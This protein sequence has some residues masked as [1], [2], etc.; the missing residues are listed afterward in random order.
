MAD[1]IE[2]LMIEVRAVDQRLCRRRGDDAGELRFGPGRRVRAGRRGARARAASGDPPRQPGVRGP[3]ADRPVGDR[4]HRRRAR[5]SPGSGRL[6]GGGG[7]SGGGGLFNLG[8][9][10]TTVLGGAS[11]QPGRATGGL[12]SAGRGYLVGERGPELFVPTAAG[13]VEPKRQARRPRGQGRDPD[14]QPARIERARKPPALQPPGRPRGPQRAHA[15]LRNRHALLACRQA[16]RAG[17]RLDP[18]VRPAVLDG[19]FPPPDA[20]RRDRA[21]AGR[22]ADRRGVPQGERSRRDHLGERRTAGTTRCSRSRPTATIRTRSCRSAGARRGC[23]RST[24][25]MVRP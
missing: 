2:Q 21:C 9:L 1:E 15:I 23:C 11:G 17:G 7:G 19:R 13:R 14:R 5:S 25:S 3:A 22:A 16:H 18:A 24:R 8:S 12:V 6:P 4:R 20:R 10:L